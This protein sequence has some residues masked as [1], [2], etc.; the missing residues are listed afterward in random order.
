MLRVYAKDPE[1]QADVCLALAQ[2]VP[3]RTY[4]S[5]A[6][7]PPS[8]DCLLTRIPLS[9]KHTVKMVEEGGI[10]CVANTMRNHRLDPHVQER[11]SL[12]L[13][14]LAANRAHPHPLCSVCALSVA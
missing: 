5:P 8:F 3:H 4:H 10:G 14:N 6:G 11:A 7:G 2:L 12:V 13:H 9:G 1:V